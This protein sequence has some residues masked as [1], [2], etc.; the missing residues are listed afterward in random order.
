MLV[1]T[2]STYNIILFIDNS[3]R[4]H[5]CG[6]FICQREREMNTAHSIRCSM[7]RI[8]LLT[9]FAATVNFNAFPNCIPEF[10]SAHIPPEMLQRNLALGCLGSQP[11]MTE[12]NPVVLSRKRDSFSSLNFIN[13]HGMNTSSLSIQP[14]SVN[15]H[16]LS[17]VITEN[18][19]G[20]IFLASVQNWIDRLCNQFSLFKQSTLRPFVQAIMTSGYLPLHVE[21]MQRHLSSLPGVYVNI[22]PNASSS[23]LS[24]TI[25]VRPDCMDQLKGGLVDSIVA[26]R[27]QDSIT[28][29]CRMPPVDT[30]SNVPLIVSWT[31]TIQPSSLLQVVSC[32]KAVTAESLKLLP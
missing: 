1:W 5:I 22:L 28:G 11:C 16:D 20:P 29:S 2:I 17:S 7:Q 4:C 27:Y 18:G 26:C 31:V 24:I 25:T 8:D 9:S 14:T 19:E 13:S 15:Q 23:K 3:Y 6:T 32:I 10:L 12:V 21:Y 30:F